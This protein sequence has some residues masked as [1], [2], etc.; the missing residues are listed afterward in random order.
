M[1]PLGVYA[2]QSIIKD[3]AGN[4][5]II[6]R[7]AWAKNTLQL[8][9]VKTVKGSRVKAKAQGFRWSNG[10]WKPATGWMDANIGRNGIGKRRQGDERSPTGL[11]RLGMSFGSVP[12]PPG[13]S[14]SYIRTTSHD[15]WACDS[16]R[17]DY[18]TYQRYSGD[19]HSRW[20][21]F[22]RLRIKPYKYVIDI[23]YNQSRTPWKG[24]AIFLH[25]WKGS[26]IGTAGCT[27]LSEAG[28]LKL[29]RWRKPRSNPLI[30]QSPYE[31]LAARVAQVR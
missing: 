14:T 1:V 5:A 3:C 10:Q 2:I 30:L 13:V 31:Q 29:L 26:G 9:I 7:R 16:R 19:P 18:N 15:Y 21:S 24:C 12:K 23:G 20:S 8:L 25:I 22:E 4:G 27:A 28:V 11:F 6:N 17:S